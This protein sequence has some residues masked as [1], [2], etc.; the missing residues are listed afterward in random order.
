MEHRL[1]WPMLAAALLVVPAIAIEQSEAS[2]PW[3]TIALFIN[4]ATWLAFLTEAL[5]MLSVV[6]SRWRWV[7]EHPLEVAIVLVTP[8]GQVAGAATEKPGLT[9]PIAQ[10]GLPNLRSPKGPCPSQPN[11]RRPPDVTGTFG[12][13]FHAP[14]CDSQRRRPVS[15]AFASLRQ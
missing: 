6:D 13:Q 7:R 14:R 3:N 1:Q 4:W 12:A 10:N 11:L 2:A 9:S 15:V 5:L 8:T